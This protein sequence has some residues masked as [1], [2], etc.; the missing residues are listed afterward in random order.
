M[1]ISPECQPFNSFVTTSPFM[2]LHNAI[3]R[4]WFLNFNLLLSVSLK[5]Y[6]KRAEAAG[7][8]RIGIY[9]TEQ[10]AGYNVRIKVP[11]WNPWL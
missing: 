2:S 4:E 7:L 11:L 8:H 1:H 9:T 3:I 10:R 6:I 5:H